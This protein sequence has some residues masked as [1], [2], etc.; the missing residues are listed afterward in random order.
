LKF[1]S[2]ERG[3][4]SPSPAYYSSSQRS[5]PLSKFERDFQT[6]RKNNRDCKETL[7]KYNLGKPRKK[8]CTSEWVG[9]ILSSNFEEEQEQDNLQQ[10]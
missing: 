8:A 2:A 10:Q 1:R 6:I 3:P 7:K 9:L 4:P 5:S